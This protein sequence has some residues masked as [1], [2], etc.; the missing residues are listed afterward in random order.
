MASDESPFRGYPHTA[1]EF[2]RR[3]LKDARAHGS[4]NAA[5][6]NLGLGLGF[7]N[8]YLGM[9]D[10]DLRDWRTLEHRT[11]TRRRVER[12]I[13]HV[14]NRLEELALPRRAPKRAPKTR[15]RRAA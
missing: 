8:R 6:V 3:A 10:A 9:F 12:V 11:R 1:V 14:R 7:A 15:K 5:V 2:A 13:D 4:R